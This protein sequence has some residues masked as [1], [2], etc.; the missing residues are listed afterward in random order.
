MAKVY[1]Y[2]IF[3]VGGN[4]STHQLLGCAHFA[5]FVLQRFGMLALCV[6]Q[7]QRCLQISRVKIGSAFDLSSVVFRPAP[8]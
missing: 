2:T 6:M 8:P 1:Q 5:H 4:R 7:C 3:W